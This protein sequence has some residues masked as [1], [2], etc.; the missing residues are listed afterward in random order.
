M[1]DFGNEISYALAQAGLHHVLHALIVAAIIEHES[2]GNPGARGDFQDGFPQYRDYP[3]TAGYRSL[4][5]M[6]VNRE[7][8]PDLAEKYDLMDPNQNIYAAVTGV[9]APAVRVKWPNWAEA[10]RMYNGSG[11]ETLLYL[12]DVLVILAPRIAGILGGAAI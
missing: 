10:I 6:Q 5:L 1:A 12:A 4:G 3:Q 11:P 9:Y 2:R 7:A 8:H